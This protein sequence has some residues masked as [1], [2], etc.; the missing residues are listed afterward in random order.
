MTNVATIVV[1]IIVV[2][3]FVGAAYFTVKGL[4]GGGC[5]DCPGCDECHKNG[6]NK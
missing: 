6:K 4:R 5:H 3:I 2:L 1:G